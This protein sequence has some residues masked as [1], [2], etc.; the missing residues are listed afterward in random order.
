[1]SSALLGIAVSGGLLYIA[2]TENTLHFGIQSVL[3]VLAIGIGAFTLMTSPSLLGGETAEQ[4]AKRKADGEAWLAQKAKEPGVYTLPSGLLF[5]QLKGSTDPA[6]KSPN[7]GDDCECHYLGTLPDGKKFDSSYDNGSPI[8]FKPNQVIKGW[9][10]AL[11]LMRE[12]DKWQVYVPYQLA[13]GASGMPPVI[14]AF[15]PLQFQME[16][17]KVSGAGRPG[18][19]SSDTLKARIGK[20]H[21]EL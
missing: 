2:F 16:L 12:G 9:T 11:Q 20:T 1:M 17:L 21:A 19:S 14:P 15:T 8:T 7:V 6:A 10:E 13:Y 5:K 4:K 3:I 18:K